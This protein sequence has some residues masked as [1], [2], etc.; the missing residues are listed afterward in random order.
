LIAVNA[1]RTARAVDF[2]IIASLK[3]GRAETPN[4]CIRDLLENTS[5][6]QF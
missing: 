3:D 1:R 6:A 5:S 4:G 2:E